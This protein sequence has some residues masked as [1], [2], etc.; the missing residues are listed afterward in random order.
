LGRRAIAIRAIGF[1]FL[2]CFQGLAP[3]LRKPLSPAKKALAATP[4][5]PFG[6][7]RSAAQICYFKFFRRDAMLASLRK[8]SKLLFCVARLRRATFSSRRQIL[9]KANIWRLA[10][11]NAF[12]IF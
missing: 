5:F 12:G 11:K 10:Q 9:P 6:G 8:N 2:C 1:G 3:C 4:S 7:S